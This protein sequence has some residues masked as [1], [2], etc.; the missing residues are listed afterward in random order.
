MNSC[1]FRVFSLMGASV[2]QLVLHREP[3]SL[4]VISLRFLKRLKNNRHD[5]S[6]MIQLKPRFV[7]WMYLIAIRWFTAIG[8]L[9]AS[10]R[11]LVLYR[12]PFF[13]FDRGLCQIESLAFRACSLTLAG[14]S[15]IVLHREPFSFTAI[16]L[17][18]IY[19]LK[20]ARMTP[21]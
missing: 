20:T 1:V 12:G 17:R 14:V 11:I 4:L 10:V 8:S 18:L 21:N 7:I 3:F 19:R 16:G 9:L 13:I 2:G 6:L 5:A 15:Q